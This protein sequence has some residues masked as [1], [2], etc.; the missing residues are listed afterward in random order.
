MYC[1]RWS[2]RCWTGRHISP[3]AV[4]STS[5]SGVPI[6]PQ[7]PPRTSVITSSHLSSAEPL[8]H[9][10]HRE[11]LVLRRE[12]VQC[13]YEERCQGCERAPRVTTPCSGELWW[14]GT[15]A[16]HGMCACSVGEGAYP[17]WLMSALDPANQAMLEIVRGPRLDRRR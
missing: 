3:T 16:V 5:P 17:G 15:A 7:F 12:R 1:H 14:A 6:S 2:P 9:D 11:H 13:Q 8:L 10:H 4:P